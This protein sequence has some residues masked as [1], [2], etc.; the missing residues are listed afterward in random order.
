MG[1]FRILRGLII[2]LCKTQ[3]IP[4]KERNISLTELYNADE[5]FCT[6]ALGEL[7]PIV[8]LDA[9]KI[10]NRFGSHRLTELQQHFEAI[11]QNYCTKF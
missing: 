11:R 2:E 5:L 7:T 9:R 10:E 3:N 6:G 8:S 4:I 1:A